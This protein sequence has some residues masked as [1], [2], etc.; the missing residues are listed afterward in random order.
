MDERFEIRIK[1]PARRVIE[2]LDPSVKSRIRKALEK[3][4]DTPYLGKPLSVPP[5]G[6]WSYRV[7]HYRIIYR[8]I[9]AKLVIIVFAVGHRQDVYSSL[10][11]VARKLRRED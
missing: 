3:L 1:K 2:R 8:I 5:A 10:K 7:G 11:S 9:E 6:Y 4:G